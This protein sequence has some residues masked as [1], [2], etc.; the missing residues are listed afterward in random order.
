LR[1]Q[2]T[3]SHSPRFVS[4]SV[5]RLSI[6]GSK[7]PKVF[8]SHCLSSPLTSALPP[9]HTLCSLTPLANVHGPCDITGIVG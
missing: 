8:C 5:F 1:V 9:R 7:K 6:P 3:S 2:K 4:I